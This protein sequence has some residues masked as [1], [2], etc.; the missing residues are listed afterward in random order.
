V[1]GFLE[2]IEAG[3]RRGEKN[4]EEEKKGVAPYI[5]PNQLDFELV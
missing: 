4:I 5:S 3:G 2:L 1:A